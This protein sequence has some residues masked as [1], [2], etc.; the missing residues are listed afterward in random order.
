MEAAWIVEAIS[1]IA[2]D[3][4]DTRL[5]ECLMREGGLGVQQARTLQAS[6]AGTVRPKAD[7]RRALRGTARWG[8]L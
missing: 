4:V 2:E 3:I 8:L 1:V 6:L 7:H 5:S